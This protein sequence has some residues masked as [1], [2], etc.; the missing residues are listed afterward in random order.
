MEGFDSGSEQILLIG[1]FGL[2]NYNY[3]AF[4]CCSAV[5]MI[6]CGCVLCVWLQFTSSVELAMQRSLSTQNNK[7]FF[8]L[9]KHFTRPIQACYHNINFMQVDLFS[10]SSLFTFF[11]SLN[12]TFLLP[13][14]ASNKIYIAIA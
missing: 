12:M 13:F 2:P 8:F 11:I 6:D 4:E 10:S 3:L 1:N 7:Y 5:W 9:L 14:Y